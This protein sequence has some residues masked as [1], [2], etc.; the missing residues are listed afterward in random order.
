[1][2]PYHP[3]S[4][5]PSA[6]TGKLR[7]HEW[8]RRGQRNRQTGLSI[9]RRLTI[10][11]PFRRSATRVAESSMSQDKYSCTCS[12]SIVWPIS[13]SANQLRFVGVGR[14]V[15][16]GLS[17][18]YPG[19]S[20]PASPGTARSLLAM[21]LSMVVRATPENWWTSSLDSPDSRASVM[22]GSRWASTSSERLRHEATAA[23]AFSC[24]SVLSRCAL[25]I[26]QQYITRYA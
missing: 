24:L 5:H 3:R 10:Q 19:V 18:G 16:E 11:I 21:I 22:T 23:R 25:S 7:C 1:M 12:S 15:A 17:D 26:P 14:R 9:D 6:L 20:M 8:P 4:G 2:S 13:Q